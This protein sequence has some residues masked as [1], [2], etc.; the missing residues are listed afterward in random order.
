MLLY[1]MGLI[2]VSVCTIVNLRHRAELRMLCYVHMM[3]CVLLYALSYVADI[4]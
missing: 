3:M 1:I 4:V 2:V